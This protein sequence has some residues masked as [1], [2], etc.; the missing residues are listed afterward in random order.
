MAKAI[1]LL[2]GSLLTG[3][4]ILAAIT[5]GVGMEAGE[6]AL[7]YPTLGYDGLDDLTVTGQGKMAIGMFLLGLAFMVGANSTA[8]KET[9]GY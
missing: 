5:G 8:W 9:G 7:I 6:T 1:L 3:L 4:G 2:V